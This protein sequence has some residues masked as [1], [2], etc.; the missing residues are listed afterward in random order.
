MLLL[1]QEIRDPLLV[2]LVEVV[3]TTKAINLDQEIIT[4]L[5]AQISLHHLMGGVEMVEMVLLH[6]IVKLYWWWR[7][8]C[9]W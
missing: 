8:W 9:R 4:T 3:K 5:A 7:R 2:V 1:L 6:H